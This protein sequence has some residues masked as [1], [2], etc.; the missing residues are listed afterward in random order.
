MNS[1]DTFRSFSRAIATDPIGLLLAQWR[2]EVFIRKLEHRPDVLAVIPS[3]SLGRGTQIGPVHDVDLIVIFDRASHPG[4]GQEGAESA[5][6]AIDE[7]DGILQTELHPWAGTMLGKETEKHTHVVTYRGDWSGPFKDIIPGAPPVDVLAAVRDGSHL[8]IP[9]RGKGWIKADPEHLIRLVE[10]RQREWKHFKAVVGMVKAWARLN[11]LKMK[12]LAVEVMVLQHCPRPGFFETMSVGDAM[13]R[14]F[15]AAAA[16]KIKGLKD[17]AGHCGEIDRKLDFGR[18]RDAL[19][20]SAVTARQA[21]DTE[22]LERSNQLTAGQVTSNELWRKLFGK[23]FPRTRKRF[24]RAQATEP[25]VVPI[26]PTRPNPRK[27]PPTGPGGG[28]PRDPDRDP[29]NRRGPQG[30]TGGRPRGPAES[31]VRKPTGPIRYAGAPGTRPREPRVRP[32]RPASAPSP[33]PTPTPAPA[34]APTGPSATVWTRVFGPTAAAA[35][36]LTFG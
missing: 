13:T 36:P 20:Q 25:W 11:D 16:A 9:E 26:E 28:G 12:N 24:W 32:Q 29:D 15:E 33:R 6:D 34:P 2:R 8:M 22:H 7:L 30:P 23:K 21:L 4:Y 3:G 10:Q 27:N 18:L 14:F 1:D 17:P 5:E 35:V 19:S 31:R